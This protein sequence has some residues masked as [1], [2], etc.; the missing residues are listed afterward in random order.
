V[1]L[2]RQASNTKHDFYSRYQQVITMLQEQSFNACLY[3]EGE[4]VK[5]H[6]PIVPTS[7]VTGEGIPDLLSVIVNY[8]SRY[9]KKKFLQKDQFNC[10][11]MEVKMIEV[12]VFH[13][14]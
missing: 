12:I 11:V 3:W 2:E 14:S 13:L 8:T 7:G 1:G 10:T 9:M 4:D 5:T 6:I